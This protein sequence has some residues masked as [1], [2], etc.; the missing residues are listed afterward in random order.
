MEGQATDGGKQ[1]FPLPEHTLLLQSRGQ[2]CDH[3]GAVWNLCLLY[4]RRGV[5]VS[6]DTLVCHIWW[7]SVEDVPHPVGKGPAKILEGAGWSR[8]KLRS[9]LQTVSP[10]AL[11]WRNITLN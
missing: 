2:V 1:W 8:S 7:R 3:L 6:A 5:R 10:A 9:K 11:G 4:P